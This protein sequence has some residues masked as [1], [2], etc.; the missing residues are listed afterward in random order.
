[1]KKFITL[2]FWH[3]CVT[4]WHTRAV[5]TLVVAGWT[6]GHCRPPLRGPSAAHLQKGFGAQAKVT[7]LGTASR[8]RHSKSRR[9]AC[10]GSSPAGGFCQGTL[11]WHDQAF[12]LGGSFYPSLLKVADSLRV[13]GSSQHSCFLPVLHGICSCLLE[14]LNWWNKREWT[15]VRL[16]VTVIFKVRGSNL[17]SVTITSILGFVC[18]GYH[19]IS[20]E[21]LQRCL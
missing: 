18:S 21:V 20:G 15:S 17:L 1:M 19:A 12:L 2:S 3:K 4:Q 16:S 9:L 7:H 14:D 6:L 13:W 8:W 5:G 10:W 11:F